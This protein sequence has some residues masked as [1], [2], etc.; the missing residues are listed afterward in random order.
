MV[1]KLEADSLS[2]AKPVQTCFHLATTARV[3]K[4]KRRSRPPVTSQAPTATSL[5]ACTTVA[6]HLLSSSKS[7]LRLRSNVIVT[8]YQFICRRPP[9]HLRSSKPFYS[10]AEPALARHVLPALPNKIQAVSLGLSCTNLQQIGQRVLL[11]RPLYP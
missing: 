4:K 7:S 1:L 5:S 10:T 8:F 3:R 2:I 6:C 9:R 11:S